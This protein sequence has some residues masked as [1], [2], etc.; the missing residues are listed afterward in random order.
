[1]RDFNNWFS[2]LTDSIYTYSYFTDFDKIYKNINNIKVELNILNSLI[3]SQNIEKEFQNIIKKYPETIKCIP[4]L[5]AI[6]QQE[7]IVNDN[8]DKHLINFTISK[9]TDVELYIKFMRETGLFD[10]LSKSKIKS[11]QDYVTGIEV[12]LDSNARKNRTGKVMEN[13]IESYI[14]SA[15]YKKHR[16]YFTQINT[17]DFNVKFGINLSLYTKTITNKKFDFVIK[18]DKKIFAIEVNFYNSQGSK[19]NETARS[20]KEIAL[21][22]KNMENFSFI[23][24]TDGKGWL[25]S[26]KNLEDTFNSINYIYNLKDVENGLFKKL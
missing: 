12:G 9:N 16:T 5:L 4:I 19:L 11:L 22:T 1:M 3:G 15:G 26:K 2:T 6:R 13:I 24:I 14:Q 21:E 7:I 20:Y 18:K 23:W 8:T 10:L 25:S 17:T